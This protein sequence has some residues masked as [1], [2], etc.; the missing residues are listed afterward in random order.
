M[1]LVFKMICQ[2]YCCNREVAHHVLLCIVKANNFP[3]QIVHFH[4]QLA[5]ILQDGSS[6]L[7]EPVQRVG[8]L[9]FP[10]LYIQFH[11]LYL[12][13]DIYPLHHL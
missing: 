12:D 6:N 7:Y 1:V 10:Y 9:Y 3:I 11:F 5:N 4:Y 2:N 8:F 13:S